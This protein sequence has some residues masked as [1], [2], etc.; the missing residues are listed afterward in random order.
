VNYELIPIAARCVAF[1]EI[2]S[3]TTRRNV[4]YTVYEAGELQCFMSDRCSRSR[5][6]LGQ[7]ECGE[8]SESKRFGARFPDAY[9]QKSRLE[10]ATGPRMQRIE[11]NRQRRSWEFH[12]AH[13]LGFD[14]GATQGVH[15]RLFR[16]VKV[17]PFLHEN[18]L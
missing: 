8:R 14:V 9:N 7:C 17:G 2:S 12:V 11:K 6:R 18:V 13:V 5:R 4:Y 16:S 3:F 1:Q 10:V 15:C